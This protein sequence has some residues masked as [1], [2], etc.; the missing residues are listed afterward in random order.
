[1]S[2]LTCSSFDPNY[3]GGY[4]NFHRCSVSPTGTCS[5]EDNK[6]NSYDYHTCSQCESFDPDYKDGY[7]NYWKEKVTPSS[8]C[9]RF[10]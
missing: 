9:S 1:M 6:S 2:C 4:C 10:S 3:K 8:T 7:C 5:K